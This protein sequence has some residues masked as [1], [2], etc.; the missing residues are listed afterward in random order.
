MNPKYHIAKRKYVI[1]IF[2]SIMGSLFVFG[3]VFAMI[4]DETE[5]VVEVS[6]VNA[7]ILVVSFI[8][9]L[10][11]QLVLYWLILKKHVFSDQEKSF[12]VEKGL[13]FKTDVW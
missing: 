1:D 7:W 4:D 11:A 8:V 12:L 10:I 9:A 5:E 2:A 3:F 6:N 13:F